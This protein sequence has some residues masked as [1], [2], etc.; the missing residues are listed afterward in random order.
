MSLGKLDISMPYEYLISKQIEDNEI[1]LLPVETHHLE[2][3]IKLP[4][5][6][7]DPFDRLIISQGISDNL[8]I[9]T[10]DRMFEIIPLREYG[11]F[12]NGFV[13]S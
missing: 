12:F 4:Y 3:L 10:C 11:D 9:L 1:N 5:Y 7:R 13:P 2:A 8:P 6:H